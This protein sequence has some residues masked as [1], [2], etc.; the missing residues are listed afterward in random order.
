MVYPPK[1][2]YTVLKGENIM[3]TRHLDIERLKK[4]REALGISKMEAAK[5]IGVSQPA[6]L[7]YESGQRI[8]SIQVIKE[9]AN[10][11]HTSVDYLLGKTSS[12]KVTSYT[13]NVA[14]SPELFALVEK[15]YSTDK[16]QLKRL[17]IYL[18]HF[19]GNV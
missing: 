4:S 2:C 8:P 9:M 12:P 15:Y 5:R 18:E 16:E 19:E 7:R 3:N 1:I 11:F 17:M 10:V 13:V 14:D 6:Y